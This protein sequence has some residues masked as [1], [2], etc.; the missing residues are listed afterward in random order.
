M[1]ISSPEEIAFRLGYIGAGELSA[2]A[3]SMNN[4]YGD[5]LMRLA[6]G[7]M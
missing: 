5:Y 1:M 4:Q 2:Q 7:K 3:K 6:D